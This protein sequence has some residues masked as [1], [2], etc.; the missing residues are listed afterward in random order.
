MT[1]FPLYFPFVTVSVREFSQTLVTLD[2]LFI[3]KDE[4]MEN[5]S[6][7]VVPG[8]VSYL[9]MIFPG[10][11]YPPQPPTMWWVQAGRLTGVIRPQER[12]FSLWD[13]S[14]Y[15]KALYI[16]GISPSFT[17]YGLLPLQMLRQDAI[18]EARICS[19]HTTKPAPPMIQEFSAFRAVR[20]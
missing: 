1:C 20:N 4:T 18:L 9:L 12:L 14:P 5:I 11:T 13:S 15:R 7:A 17:F 3:F 16:T 2:C 6:K 19:H 10:W 8:A